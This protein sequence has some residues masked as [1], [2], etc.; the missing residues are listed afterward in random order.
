MHTKSKGVVMGT[1]GLFAG[2]LSV[3]L[4]SWGTGPKALLAMGVCVIVSLVL[5]AVLPKP[6]SNQQ[7]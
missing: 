2:L 7:E 3:Q 5:F 4:V 1:G 6:T